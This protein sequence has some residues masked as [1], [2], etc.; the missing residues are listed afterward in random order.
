MTSGYLGAA[1]LVLLST[2]LLRIGGRVASGETP[3]SSK[4]ALRGDFGD[5]MTHLLLVEMIR[6]NGRRMPKGTPDF[7]LAGPQDYPAF[8]HWLLSFLPKRTVERWEWL[9]S[10]AIEAF[11]AALI[12]GVFSFCIAEYGTVPNPALAMLMTLAW[13]L[14]PGLAM[15]MR[16]TAYLNERV[17]GFLFSNAYFLALAF[18]LIA[19]HP[20]ALGAALVAGCIV[21]VSSKFGMQA[22]VLVT[23]L[24]ALGL[25][26]A[27]PLF[28]LVVLFGTA[29]VVTGGYALF[30]WKG[31]LRHTAFYARYLVHVGDYVTSFSTR[32][33]VEV[34][35]LFRRGSL[36]SA[37]RLM[38][39]H[40]LAKAVTNSPAVWFA[41]AGVLFGGTL[42]DAVRIPVVL[43]LSAVAVALVTSTDSFK[44]LGEGERY[45]EIAIAPAI[46]VVAMTAPDPVTWLGILIAYSLSRL[47]MAWLP[48]MR[49]RQ[50]NRLSSSTDTQAL[51]DWLQKEP[52]HTI[53]AVPGRLAY[54]IAY[55]AAQHRYV[56]WFINAPDRAKQAD[57]ERLFEGGARY[58]YPNPRLAHATFG[59]ANADIAVIH[60][61]TATGC[62][63][64]WG[65]DYGQIV[66][67]LLY[68]NPTYY[69]IGL[70][71]KLPPA[72]EAT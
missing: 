25:L 7:I 24:M 65:I 61:P 71:T 27:R 54:P 66:G 38:L 69:V 42:A 5:A 22:I 8:F 67:E 10:P 40:P 55:A 12:F 53:F 28:L 21:A 1:G 39:G 17:F 56:W 9:S 15:D 32:Q 29:M 30:V 19:D 57:F 52:P 34:A 72:S 51:L 31:S 44:Y 41:L 3:W 49:N 37:L 11:H 33:F 23:P 58:P 6:R 20:A 18:W 45:L 13:F 2:L 26:D 68:S 35:R 60:R 59:D 48:L 62:K 64:V 14:S 4:F 46:M 63:D 50:A 36:R 16:R 47:A 70:G 43:I